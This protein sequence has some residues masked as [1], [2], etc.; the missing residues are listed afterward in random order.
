MLFAAGE[1]ASISSF[2]RQVCFLALA[3]AVAAC[4]TGSELSG[5]TLNVTLREVARG[6]QQAR[7]YG[8]AISYYRSLRQRN[9]DD[10]DAGLGLA[11]NLRY[12]GENGEALELTRQL[13]QK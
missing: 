7:D 5:E 3:L 12:A 4:E 8:A 2:V 9:P 10:L 6:S 1:K 11:R 13:A